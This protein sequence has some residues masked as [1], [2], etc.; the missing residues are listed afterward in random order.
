MLKQRQLDILKSTILHYISTA[1][2]VGSKAL[3]EKDQFKVSSATIRSEL[4]E[5]EEYGYLTHLH[6]SSGRVPTDLGYR[7]YVDHLQQAYFLPK[8]DRLKI[9]RVFEQHYNEIQD[10]YEAFAVSASRFFPGMSLAITSTRLYQAGLSNLFHFPDF[11]S[12]EILRKI[13]GGLEE[14]RQIQ[15]VVFSYVSTER[16]EAKVFIGQEIP[17]ISFHD[18]SLLLKPVQDIFSGEGV[19]AFLGPRRLRYSKWFALLDYFS[20]LVNFFSLGGQDD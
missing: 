9:K 6:T 10:P 5:L 19:I 4:S 3:L 8:Q 17:L 16:G 13:V 20:E 7:F 2:P 1:E 11:D 18:C 15:R 12:K 14:Y